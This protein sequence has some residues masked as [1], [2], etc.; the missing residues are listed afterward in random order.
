MCIRSHVLLVPSYD[1]SPISFQFHVLSLPSCAF[2]PIMCF[3][4]HHVLSVPCA[5]SPMCFQSH[6]VLSVPL[7]AF[8][9]IMWFQS[10]VLSVPCA[11][12]VNNVL[13]QSPIV[14]ELAN[15]SRN[16][17]FVHLFYCLFFKSKLLQ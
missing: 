5:F 11:F 15:K 2:R 4:T 9:P 13:W 3:Q 8:S 10:H 16:N 7:C 1:F 6:H 12:G 17:L 14:A